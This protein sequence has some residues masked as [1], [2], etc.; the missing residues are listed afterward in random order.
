MAT[1]SLVPRSLAAALRAVPDET[2]AALLRARPDLAVPVPADMEALTIR[3]RT[4]A[5][6]SRALDRLDEF[7]LR[8]LDGLRLVGTEDE[9]GPVTSVNLLATVTPD[10]SDVGVAIATL[11]GLGLVWGPDEELRHPACLAEVCGPY[12]AGLGRPAAELSSEAGKLVDDAAAL[13][14]TVLAAPPQSRTVLD[15]LAAGPPLGT[16]TDAYAQTPA[17]TPVRWL[18]AHHLLVPVAADTVELPREVGVLLRREAGPLGTLRRQPELPQP[19][20]PVAVDS[21]GTAQ[22]C[23]VVR[24]TDLLLEVLTAEAPPEVKS[25]GIGMQALHRLAR[26]CDLSDANAALLLE[27]CFAAGLLGRD[28]EAWMPSH[29]YDGWR[30]APLSMRWSRLA[31]AWLDAERDIRLLGARPGRTR[32][33]TVL[34]PSLVSH[35]APRYRR[36]V[37]RLL[38][39]QAPGTPIDTEL[40]VEVCGWRH[41]RRR[42]DDAV[43]AVHTQA[44]FLGIIARDAVT[45]FGRLLVAEPDHDDPLGIH[46]PETDPLHTT[47]DD[48]LP[49]PID[50]MVVQGDL[51]VIVPGHP[52]PLLAAELALVAERESPTV[53]RVTEASLRAALD[54]GYAREDIRGVFARRCPGELPQA[55]DYLIDDVAKRHGGL[56]AGYA[57]SYVR[58]EDE[59]LLVQVLA[60]RRLADAALRRLAPTV[61]VSPMPLP[62]LLSMLREAGHTPVAEDSS[63][64]IVIDKSVAPRATRVVRPD[65]TA[66]PTPRVEGAP[67]AALVEH[68][69][70]TE[71][72]AETM[73]RGQR[74]DE[75]AVEVLREAVPDRALVWVEYVDGGGEPIRKLLRP[76]SMGAGYL[77]A[78][79]KRTDML[80]TIALHTIRSATIASV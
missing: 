34:S 79:D 31:R 39:E 47:L 37:L 63:G 67:L 29:G 3:A 19:I 64:S 21:A 56:R 57:G 60:D 45:E 68:L 80:H 49:V 13:R 53:H 72:R 76:V 1:H 61:I 17:D 11:R 43:R 30:S 55:L 38:A 70:H 26:T 24:L 18:L 40:T 28:G 42:A 66:D 62:G 20:S 4:P 7:T 78:E 65:K 25:G 58:S 15:K 23:E 75:D 2:L 71:P 10:L 22:V 50:E 44:S 16:V 27:A 77:R 12:P 59:A 6:V 32:P 14:R 51:T 9:D 36:E 5:S 48:L 33:S 69:K 54:A 41:P 74:L 8:V 46:T 35:S 52:S 73:A